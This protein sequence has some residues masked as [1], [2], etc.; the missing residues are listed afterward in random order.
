M[1]QKTNQIQQLKNR[2]QQALGV[3]RS[4]VA[5]LA[6]INDAIVTEQTSRK[7]TIEQLNEEVAVLEE[8]RTEN[9]KFIGKINDFLGLETAND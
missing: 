4:T 8:Q 9:A 5:S 1:F 3:F 6:S 2:S 7:A